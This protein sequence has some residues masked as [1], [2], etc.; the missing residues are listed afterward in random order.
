M[1]RPTS[2]VA[3]NWL[4]QQPIDIIPIIGSRKLAQVQENLS[5]LEFELTPEQMQQLDSISAIELGFPHDFLKSPMVL[6]FAFGGTL[7]KID[8]HRA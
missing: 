3:L 4:R 2:Q 6:D 5:S 1:G 8:N 7:A